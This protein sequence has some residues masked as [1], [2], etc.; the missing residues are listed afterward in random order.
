MSY[1]L[2]RF[3]SVLLPE[4][5]ESSDAGTGGSRLDLLELPGGGVFDGQGTGR[6]PR[7][8]TRPGMRVALLAG[9][10]ADLRE[11]Y[12]ELRALRGTR[13]QLYRRHVDGQR[14]WIQARLA[15]VE[16]R[17]RP[18]NLR[19][20]ELDL[21]FV[22]LSAFWCGLARDITTV[23]DSSPKTV[24]LPNGGNVAT[25]D[26]VLTLTAGSEDID[27]VTVTV[28]G[29][30]QWT[31]TGDLNPGQVLVVDCG[32]RSVEKGGVDAYSGFALGAGHTIDDWLRLEPGNN[33]VVVSVTVSA[34]YSYS[35]SAVA[36]A[37]LRAQYCDAWE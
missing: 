37:T 16:T 23:L 11:R 33:N 6:S 15:E 12:A 24:V 1:W 31:W 26:V 2:E 8:L 4:G 29:V 17:W 21:R 30:S 34:S 35:Y 25:N 27:Q 9:C 18:D 22:L 19:H 20:L 13:D 14:E 10:P 32:A 36:T 7:E 5:P 3:G 28:A